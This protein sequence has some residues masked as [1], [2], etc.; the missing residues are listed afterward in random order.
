MASYTETVEARNPALIATGLAIWGW[1]IRIVVFIAFLIIPVVIT[2]VTP[3]VNYGST[4]ATYAARY[5]SQIAFVQAHPTVAIT[6]QKYK[7]QLTNAAK[8]APELAVIKAHP[9]LFAKLASY[10]SPAAI[11]PNL[12]AQAVTAAGGGATG[13]RILTTIGANGP[14]IN[15]V[16]AVAPKLA[17][18]A[19]YS[20]QLA[21]L[22]KVPPQVLP[23]MAAHGA[24]VQK[25]AA[26]APSQWRTWYWICFGGIV[27]F[28]LSIP[29]LRGRWRPSRARADEEAHDAMVAAEL[30]KLTAASGAS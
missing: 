29:L 18:L 13:T 25:A 28:L 9:A 17:P 7:T 4:V 5:R 8:F 21:A 30:A 3:L 6:A 12:L 15:G 2:S 26:Q 23:Y 11:P 1:I 27:F 10:P 20:A 22:A 24:A 19:P 14:A 16:I